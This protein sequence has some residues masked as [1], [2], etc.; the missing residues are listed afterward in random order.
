MTE[1]GYGNVCVSRGE[2]SGASE[3]VRTIDEGIYGMLG[4]GSSTWLLVALKEGGLA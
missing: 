2:R 1:E 3:E 4:F